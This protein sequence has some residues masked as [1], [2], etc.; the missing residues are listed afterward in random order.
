MSFK[1]TEC[2][3]CRNKETEVSSHFVF[4]AQCQMYFKSLKDC[5]SLEKENE[6]YLQHNNDVT[7]VNYLTYLSKLFSYLPK[8]LQGPVLDF[9]CGP[10][11][12]VEALVKKEKL[13]IEVHSYDPIY[14]PEGIS[15]H[16]KYNKIYASECFEH[17]LNPAKTIGFISDLQDSDGVLAIRTE[18]YS[19]SKGPLEKWWYFKD[20]AHTCFYTEDTIRW[21]AERFNYQIKTL[22]SPYIVLEKKCI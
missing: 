20:P 15:K 4:C 13:N 5:L 9:G 7:D 22:D 6:R 21:L 11:K 12:G 3:L 8:D 18:L 2:R 19:L 1:D 17:F 16:F 14:F 10:T